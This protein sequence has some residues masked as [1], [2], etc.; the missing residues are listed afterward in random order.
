MKWLIASDIHGDADGAARLIEAFRSEG[1]SRLVLLGDILYHGPRN[2]L[3]ERYDPKEVAAILNRERRH[4]V[5]VRGNCDSEV[6]QMMLEFPILADYA[7]IALRE[8][9]VFATHGHVFNTENV[10]PMTRGDVLLCGHTHVP[11]CETF[12]DGFHYLNPGAVSFPKNGSPRSY[13]T[14]E[15][16]VF[17]W[18]TLEG[19]RYR[20][21]E[22]KGDDE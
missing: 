19:E 2:G 16:G 4:T 15:D 21:F 22:L 18:K 14:L 5:S 8:R 17:S 1:A 13:M 6:D 9:T 7:L 20:T 12:G 3:P 11:A 10:P